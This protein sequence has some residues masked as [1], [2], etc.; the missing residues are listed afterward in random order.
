MRSGLEVQAGECCPLGLRVPGSQ[1]SSPLQEEPT[2]VLLSRRVMSRRAVVWPL[3]GN[4]VRFPAMAEGLRLR[5]TKRLALGHTAG[6][7][8]AERGMSAF[9]CD[10]QR[11][12][13]P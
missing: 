11:D 1:P 5:D 12:L 9:G 7:E 3:P 8:E 6:W 2:G 4:A 13:P 10:S